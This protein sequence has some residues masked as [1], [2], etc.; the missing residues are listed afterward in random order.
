MALREFEFYHGA[1]ITKILRKD[2]P[3]TLTLI[4]T[5]IDKSWSAYKISDNVVDKVI[6]MKYCASPRETSKRI[7][8]VFNF[9]PKHLG[10]LSRYRDIDLYLALICVNKDLQFE[11]ME[12]CLLNR[13]EISETIDISSNIG[14]TITVFCKHRRMLRV[15]GS[16]TN[17]RE[18]K[19]KRG[20]ID[21]FGLVDNLVNEIRKV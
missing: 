2:M 14:Q 7:A 5:D 16:S 20:R 1:V 17:R 9:T 19:I 18:L 12:V 13:D 8:W 4:E 15:S 11:P 10:E 21:D 6:Y 3:V